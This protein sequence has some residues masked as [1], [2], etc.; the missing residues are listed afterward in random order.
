MSTTAFRELARQKPQPEKDPKQCDAYGCKCRASVRASGR[1]W[2]CFAHAFAEVDDWQK[3]TRGLNDHDW[4]L[5]LVVEVRKMDREH[6]DWRN[7][8]VQ[9]WAAAD[10]F[11][12]PQPFE[13]CVPYQNRMLMEL[14]HRIGQSA[15]RPQPRNPADVKPSGRFVRSDSWEFE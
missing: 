10:P 9:F 1:G 8:A 11:C 4:L 12:A 6:Q 14:L 15:K 5:G 3:I 2:A 13:G 7:F